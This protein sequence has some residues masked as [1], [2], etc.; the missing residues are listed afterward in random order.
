MKNYDE[1]TGLY[2]LSKT[3]QFEAIPESKTAEVFN[4]FWDNL[5]EQEIN[6]K[7]NFFSVDKN[8]SVATEIIK[9]ILND[10]HERFINYA[11]SSDEIKNYVS[12]YLIKS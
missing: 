9:I 2:S 7:T 11:L 4:S 3:I 8:L 6:G 12:K 1:L 5:A 10:F